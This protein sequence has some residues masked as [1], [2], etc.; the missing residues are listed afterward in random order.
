MTSTTEENKAIVRRWFEEVMNQGDLNAVDMICTQCAPSF[1]VNKGVLDDAPGGLD[2]VKAVVQSL[3]TAF[4]DLEF[5]IEDQIA[6]GNKV[7]SQMTVSGTHMGDMMG[8]PPTNKRMTI[9]GVSIWLV[10][11]GKLVEEW[12]S[13]DTMAMMRQL[14]AIPDAP[15]PE[16]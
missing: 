13:W 3:R 4:P 1:V 9:N 16:A 11:E 8:L 15:P 10:G 6:E 2:G 5:T 14:G 12:V 7:V